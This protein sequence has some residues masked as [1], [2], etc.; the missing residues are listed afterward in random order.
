MK[1]YA[2][3]KLNVL[4]KHSVTFQYKENMLTNFL[5]MLLLEMV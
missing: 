3:K 1:T 4:R 5:Y 2:N